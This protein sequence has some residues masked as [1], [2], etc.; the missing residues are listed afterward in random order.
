MIQSIKKE[1]PLIFT[2]TYLEK[3]SFG[4][5]LSIITAVEIE[6]FYYW[7]KFN[8]QDF[9]MSFEDNMYIETARDEGR[10][11][12]ISLPHNYTVEDFKKFNETWAHIFKNISDFCL[13]Q[14]GNSKSGE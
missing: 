8:T 12:S 6:S 10:L 14:S 1:Q 5:W 7:I 3:D 4:N 13:K 9:Y 2:N 11:Y